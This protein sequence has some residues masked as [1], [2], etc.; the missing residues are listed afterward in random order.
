MSNKSAISKIDR[1]RN[2]KNKELERY[3]TKT[4][5]EQ[6]ILNFFNIEIN[7]DELKRQIINNSKENVSVSSNLQLRSNSLRVNT[8]ELLVKQK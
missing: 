2:I 1:K 7:N 4:S 8:S 3:L 5:N 6:S